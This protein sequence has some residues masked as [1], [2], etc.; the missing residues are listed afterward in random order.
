MD[1]SDVS[2][3]VVGGGSIGQRHIGNLRT[4]GVRE[5]SVCDP[6]PERRA[7]L[8][9]EHAVTTYT[10]FEEA[11]ASANPLAVLICTPPHLH[12]E[13]AIRAVESGAHVFIEK[14]LSNSMDGVDRL[15][16]EAESRQRIVQVGYNWRF[17]D[18]LRKIKELLDAGAI[19]RVMWARAETGQ[20]LPEWRPQLDYRQNYTAR[21]AMGG[22]IIL[23]GS[24]EI[25]YVR[26]LLG[27]VAQV[28]CQAGTLSDLEVDVEDTASIILTFESG[29]VGEVHLDFVQ[30]ARAR[31]C[32][33]VGT[34]GT[35]I[36]DHITGSLMIFAAGNLSWRSFDL[37]P[38]PN[39][40]YLA[41]MDDFMRCAIGEHE[42]VVGLHAGVRV[43]EIA[44]AALES[45]M[46]GASVE[47]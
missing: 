9:S 2:V 11:L 37:D 32:K 47:L 28:Y 40:K 27:E 39:A 8:E 41:E 20:Y 23:D 45:T 26:W 6:D 18:G 12:V 29:C 30:R 10:S 1:N 24:H 7:A 25:D 36:W 14:P 35:I 44:L 46:T 5:L 16:Q 13:L 15:I 19:G 34:E 22:G 4:L 42:P 17:H 43:M 21:R 3:L 38:D 33:I 31:N